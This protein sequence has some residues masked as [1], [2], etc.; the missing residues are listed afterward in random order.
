MLGTGELGHQ[1]S[2]LAWRPAFPLVAG[3]YAAALFG[4]GLL[5]RGK[6]LPVRLLM[7]AALA[8]MHLGYGIGSWVA[9][10]DG[11]WQR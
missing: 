9:I 11:L 2:G 1:L 3:G 6:R 7:P 8:A 5:A 4:A 10:L